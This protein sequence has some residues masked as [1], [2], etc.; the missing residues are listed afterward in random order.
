[1]ALTDGGADEIKN[2]WIQDYDIPCGAHAKDRLEVKLHHLICI[3]KTITIEQAQDALMHDWRIAYQKY[4][5][6]KGCG[7]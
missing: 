1:M 3:E 2:L 4:V 7:K 6:Q 5:D